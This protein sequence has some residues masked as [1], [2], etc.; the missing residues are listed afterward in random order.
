MNRYF[1][2]RLRIAF[3]MWRRRKLTLKKAFNL[4]HCYIAYAL[5]L[6]TSAP[7]PYLMNFELREILSQC[8]SRRYAGKPFSSVRIFKC[9]RCHF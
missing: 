8:K 1:L 9:W 5:K 7:A 3:V 2:L 6:R 4:L